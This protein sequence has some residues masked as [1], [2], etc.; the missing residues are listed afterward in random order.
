[1]NEI[2][3]CPTP[4]VVQFNAHHLSDPPSGL[5]IISDYS[6]WW[7]ALAVE[8]IQLAQDMLILHGG[9]RYGDTYDALRKAIEEAT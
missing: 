3:P 5:Y 9:H 8:A 7:K 6:A 1:M 2:A 4:Y